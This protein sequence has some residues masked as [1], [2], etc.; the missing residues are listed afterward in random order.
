MSREKCRN[1]LTMP[2]F[3][4][5]L[6]HAPCGAPAS[7][8]ETSTRGGVHM[9]ASLVFGMMFI[10][11]TAVWAQSDSGM[12]CPCE[13]TTVSLADLTCTSPH[14]CTD[15]DGC[16]SLEFEA[17]CTGYYKLS[18]SLSCSGS[19]SD[20]NVCANV[21]EGSA[22]KGNCH[23]NPCST[24]GNSCQICLIS[25]HTYKLY[26]CLIACGGV[27]DCPSP[28]TCTASGR[29]SYCGNGNTVCQ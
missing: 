28:A 25:G 13:D 24:C 21:Y 27:E 7:Q 26:V 29:L 16:S 5:F 22:L 8:G 23:D 6:W 17:A 9:K 2:L 14:N 12:D 1:S 4:S 18:V 15:Q 3:L 10:L 11:T 20:Y 19:C